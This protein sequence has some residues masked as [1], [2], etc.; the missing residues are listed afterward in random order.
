MGLRG[1]QQTTGLP[2]ERH[3]RLTILAEAER[4]PGGKRRVRCLCDCGTETVVQVVHL[5]RGVSKSCGCLHREL[6]R[7]RAASWTAQPPGLRDPG[8]AANGYDAVHKEIRSMFG[9]ATGYHCVSCGAMAEQ[10]SYSPTLP[11]RFGS[12][13]SV[14]TLHDSRRGV[15]REVYYSS[16][17]SAY[18][19]RCRSCHQSHDAAVAKARRENEAGE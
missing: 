9:K 19:P 15:D 6:A 5:R 1:P 14:V 7:A 16:E 17:P 12:T 10:W 4:T 2:G 18:L 11:K 3:N 8:K 13:E